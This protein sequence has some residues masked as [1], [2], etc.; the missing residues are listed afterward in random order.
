MEQFSYLIRNDQLVVGNYPL[1]TEDY[2]IWYAPLEIVGRASLAS[3]RN[4]IRGV[5]KNYDLNVSE[6]VLM[7]SSAPASEF[8][9]DYSIYEPVKIGVLDDGQIVLD[10][11]VELH[12]THVDESDLPSLLSP[13]L[14][15][16][17]ATFIDAEIEG[18]GTQVYCEISVAFGRRG[19]AVQEAIK[20]G[21]DVVTLIERLRKST[22]TAESALEL[23]TAGRAD[24]MVGLPESSW[25]EVK[26]QGYDLKTDRDR[27]ELAQDIA[28]FAN[29]DTGGLLVIGMRTHRTGEE[30][31]IAK[32]SPALQPFDA[33]RYHRSI[34]NKLFPPIQGLIIQNV[35]VPISGGRSG[36]MLAIYIPAQPEEMKPFLVHG[37][38]VRGQVEGAFISIV[39]RRGE[40]SIP[41][42]AQAI[43]ATLAAGRA[44]LRRSEVPPPT[45]TQV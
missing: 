1:A 38:I 18:A 39:Q 25:L 34:D 14:A 3:F 24:L 44:L 29:G 8:D 23:V 43:H 22:F 16:S 35:F 30:E 21:L 40:H 6:L 31:I 36:S 37:A 10:I 32:T 2:R 20:I 7:V 15:R 17:H 4:A 19:A 12:G 41:I 45:D 33:G 28:R 27:I 13:L 11:M 5:A 9:E 26:S 42:T